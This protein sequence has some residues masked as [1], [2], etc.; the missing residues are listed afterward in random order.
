MTV[1]RAARA[2]LLFLFALTIGAAIHAQGELTPVK[3]VVSKLLG[4][5]GTY[6]ADAV[7]HFAEQGIDVEFVTVSSTNDAE[8]LALLLQGNIDVLQ[9]GLTPGLFNAVT[10]GETLRM[11]AVS[12]YNK[13]DHC[14][15]NA[16][17]VAPGQAEGFDVES[18]RG[19]SVAVPNGSAQYYLDTYLQQHGMTLT[20]VIIENI[21]S[22]ARP[23]AL[24]NGSVALAWMNEPAIAQAIQLYGLDILVGSPEIVPNASQGVLLFGPSMLNREDDLAIRYL[25]AYLQGS[26]QFNE[27]PTEQTLELLSTALEVEPDLLASTCWIAMRDNGEMA[28]E[29]V[30][31]YQNW[32]NEQDLLDAIVPVEDIYDPSFVRAAAA[33]LDGEVASEMA[34]EATPES[35]G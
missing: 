22:S 19:A 9:A 24:S 4:N 20:D 30:M 29:T 7:G 21:P 1:L 33:R 28:T 16:F 12:S 32:L 35:G 18:L 6:L 25:V 8:A 11:V 26:R 34:P 10:R 27:G 2:V 15:Y 5:S 17:M 31:D 14:A 3:V 23:E 13:P